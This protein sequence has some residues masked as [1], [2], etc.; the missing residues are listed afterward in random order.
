[1]IICRAYLEGNQR[2]APVRF[3]P[4]Q[5]WTGLARRRTSV[6]SAAHNQ[7]PISWLEVARRHGRA[8][9]IVPVCLRR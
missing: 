7:T 8:H 4:A 3:G 6:D 1:V 5:V 9:L 2:S